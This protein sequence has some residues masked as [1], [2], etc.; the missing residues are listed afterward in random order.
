MQAAMQFGDSVD[1]ADVQTVWN[2]VMR[3][4][5]ALSNITKPGGTTAGAS[6]KA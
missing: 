6:N 3:Q 2:E 4:V 5:E 1:A